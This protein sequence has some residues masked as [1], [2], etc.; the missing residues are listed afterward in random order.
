MGNPKPVRRRFRRMCSG[1]SSTPVPS[2]CL[3]ISLPGSSCACAATGRGPPHPRPP[4]S[5]RALAAPGR[6]ASTLPGGASQRHSEPTRFRCPGHRDAS[7]S[8]RVVARATG[9]RDDIDCKVFTCLCR[10]RRK[11][12][13]RGDAA[14]QS[15]LKPEAGQVAQFRGQLSQAGGRGTGCTQTRVDLQLKMPSDAA[16]VIYRYP[17]V[18]Q[19]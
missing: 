6:P 5:E 3:P 14:L 19:L 1:I 9:C 15:R 11:R 7:G 10:R 12:W 17:D 8:P 2:N 4:L 13:I 18:A 16:K